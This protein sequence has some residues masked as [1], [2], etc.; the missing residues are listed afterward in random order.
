M[1]WR[2]DNRDLGKFDLVIGSD[3]LYE[4]AHPDA[5]AKSL[6]S[7]LNPNGK[8]ILSDPGRAYV[9]KFVLSMNKLGYR[10]KMYIEKVESNWTKKEIF[11]FEF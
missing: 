7:F 8:I 3:I 4:S 6:T 10:E 11:I 9:Q 2:N 5:V 1:N